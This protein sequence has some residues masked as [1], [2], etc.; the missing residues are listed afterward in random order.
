MGPLTLRAVPSPPGLYPSPGPY[1]GQAQPVGTKKNL[2]GKDEK[3]D[4][5][6]DPAPHPG[7][8]TTPAKAKTLLKKVEDPGKQHQPK[9]A[10]QTTGA[11]II[12]HF[13]LH[14]F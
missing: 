7:T 6:D 4:E 5:Q 3:Q 2:T 8:G 9:Q 1:R 12:H 14:G 11:F 13:G 10:A